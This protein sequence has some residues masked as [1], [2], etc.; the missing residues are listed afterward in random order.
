MTNLNITCL[1]FGE[2]EK[3]SVKNSCSVF[4]VLIVLTANFFAVILCVLFSVFVCVWVWKYACVC[5][6]VFCELSE[7]IM[8]LPGRRKQPGKWFEQL[9]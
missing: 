2:K 5:A 1:M 6:C 3:K 4:A 7:Q 8:G 9:L